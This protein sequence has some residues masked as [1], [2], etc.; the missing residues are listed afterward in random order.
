MCN[1]STFPRMHLI[2]LD[3]AIATIV[4]QIEG[5]LELYNWYKMNIIISEDL[6]HWPSIIQWLQHLQTN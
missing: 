3:F 6:K 4:E 5:F 1:M 2:Q